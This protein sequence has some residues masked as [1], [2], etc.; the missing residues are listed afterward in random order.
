MPKAAMA[1]RVIPYFRVGQYDPSISA[2]GTIGVRFGIALPKIF[3]IIAGLES[4]FGFASVNGFGG[5]DRF[6]F[7][8]GATY[9]VIGLESFFK[10]KWYFNVE[11]DI[12]AAYGSNGVGAD[13]L[14]NILFGFGYQLN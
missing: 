8:D 4:R 14:F 3:S 13:P 6:N 11:N 12:G 5:G 1:L 7:F 9:A 2:G 10:D